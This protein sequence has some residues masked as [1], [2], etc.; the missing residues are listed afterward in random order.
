MSWKKMRTKT[1]VADLMSLRHNLESY[2]FIFIILPSIIP[3]ALLANEPA[4]CEYPAKFSFLFVFFFLIG[5]DVCIFR[6]VT[7][8]CMT[9]RLSMLLLLLLAILKSNNR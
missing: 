4:W 5:F 2:L 9:V 1:R 6:P 3:D 7:F 8:L